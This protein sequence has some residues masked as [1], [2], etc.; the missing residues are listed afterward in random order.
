MIG[1]RWWPALAAAGALVG[2]VLLSGRVVFPKRRAPVL[3][4]RTGT[5]SAVALAEGTDRE[6]AAMSLA[7]AS[8]SPAER[9]EV[10]GA[11]SYA[12]ARLEARVLPLGEDL[13]EGD[14]LEELRQSLAR[15]SSVLD[16]ARS[17]ELGHWRAEDLDVRV[18]GDCPTALSSDQTCIPLWAS[19]DD[20][21]ALDGRARFF[22]WPV[23]RAAVVEL[24]SSAAAHACAAAIL[25]QGRRDATSIA[26]VLT[27]EDLALRP[28]PER[29]ELE[30]A[31]RRLGVAMAMNRRENRE[32]LEALGRAAPVGRTAPWLDMNPSTVLVVPRLSALVRLAD[33]VNEVQTTTGCHVVRWLHRP[34]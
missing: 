10:A 29:A 20:P 8:L 34:G 22:A 23:S 1:G 30:G 16:T 5:A 13:G 19:A 28:V 27:S 31:A 18:L 26:L 21:S 7:I 33:L 12:A 11:M 25:E 15:Y 17:F 6:D 24:A 14:P 9:E 32:R 2:A 4:V 3:L